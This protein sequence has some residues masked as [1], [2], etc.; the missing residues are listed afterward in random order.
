MN[1]RDRVD[2]VI[3]GDYYMVCRENIGPTDAET[4][5]SG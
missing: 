5:D 2:I 1:Q 4:T 3:S